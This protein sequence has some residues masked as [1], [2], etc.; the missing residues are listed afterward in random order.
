MVVDRPELDPRG[1]RRYYSGAPP[2]PLPVAEPGALFRVV[3]EALRFDEDDLAHNR[4]GA[5]SPQQ[6]GGAV[7][8]IEGVLESCLEKSGTLP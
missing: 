6:G 4:R 2:A 3:S 7:V 1:T 8:I 5:L